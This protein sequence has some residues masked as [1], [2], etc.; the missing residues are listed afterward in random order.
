MRQE[1]RSQDSNDS[2]LDSLEVMEHTRCYWAESVQLQKDLRLREAVPWRKVHSEW[3][4]GDIQ[5]NRDGVRRARRSRSCGVLCPSRNCVAG[6]RVSPKKYA[7]CSPWRSFKREDCGV[8]GFACD[9]RYHWPV[10]SQCTEHI[11][12]IKIKRTAQWKEI[13]AR[14]H[15]NNKPKESTVYAILLRQAFTWWTERN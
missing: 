7:G 9:W 10:S 8:Q 5:G 3:Y 4:L 6:T 15:H 1:W 11:A 2:P 14:G 12:Y 13:H